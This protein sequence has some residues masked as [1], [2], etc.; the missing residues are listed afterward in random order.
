[1]H[2]CMG[3]RQTAQPLTETQFK[4]PEPFYNIHFAQSGPENRPPNILNTR[5]GYHCFKDCLV[6]LLRGVVFIEGQGALMDPG[7]AYAVKDEK[8]IG[9]GG[10]T[11]VFFMEEG[12]MKGICA[13]KTKES[14]DKYWAEK[15]ARERERNRPW[16]KVLRKF[17]RERPEQQCQVQ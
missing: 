4:R 8:M 14:Q 1:M 10:N 3:V 6:F 11:T 12:E 15:E 17:R 16:N 7:Y 2:R 13:Q 9:L 5:V